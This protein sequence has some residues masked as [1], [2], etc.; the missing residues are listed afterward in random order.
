[1]APVET[2]A[3]PEQ[4]E[5]PNVD[6]KPETVQN[7]STDPATTGHQQAGSIDPAMAKSLATSLSW[8]YVFKGAQIKHC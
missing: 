3:K 6:H 5:P 4:P 1:M 2:T 7:S 8:E